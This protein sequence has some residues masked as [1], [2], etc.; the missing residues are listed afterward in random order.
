MGKTKV[1]EIDKIDRKLTI[2]LIIELAKA[3]LTSEEIGKILGVGSSTVRTL[4]PYLSKI[5]GEK[6]EEKRKSERG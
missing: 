1:E 2:L 4:V 6:G 3:G 5:K